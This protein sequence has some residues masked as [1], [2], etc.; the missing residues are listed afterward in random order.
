[1]QMEKL[2]ASL[3]K[4]ERFD[5]KEEPLK[6]K[7]LLELLGKQ[8]RDYKS[9]FMLKVGAK[10]IAVPVEKIAYFFSKD[11]MTYI[12]TK[13]GKKLPHDQSLEI[14]DEQLN[15]DDFFRANRQYIVSF[16]SISEIHP[17]FKGRVKIHLTPPEEDEV[18]I[19]A[20][21]TPIFKKWLDQ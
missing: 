14:I 5:S 4:L 2:K 10:I 9:R 11:K 19:S 15:P 8:S 1:V 17:Y 21:K 20:D 12:V 7:Q 16:E 3:E 6:Y 13:E 18:V